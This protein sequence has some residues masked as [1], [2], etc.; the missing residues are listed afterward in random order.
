M[1]PRLA[2]VLEVHVNIQLI[3]SEAGCH[4]AVARNHC[5]T[6]LNPTRIG[7]NTLRDS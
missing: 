1:G 2:M 7:G 6:L 5:C 3:M 4:V